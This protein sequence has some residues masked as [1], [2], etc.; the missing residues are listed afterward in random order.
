MNVAYLAS[1]LHVH[2]S[3]YHLPEYEGRQYQ[4]KLQ[5]GPR[6]HTVVLYVAVPYGTSTRDLCSCLLM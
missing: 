4:G 2:P 5:L 1:P 6:A 3:G